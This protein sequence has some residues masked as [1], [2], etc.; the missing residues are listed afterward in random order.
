MSGSAGRGA[1]WTG[2][3]KAASAAAVVVLAVVAVLVVLNRGGRRERPVTA[4]APLPQKVD[5]KVRI[6]YVEFRG[7]KERVEF[8]A[9]RTYIGPDDM[10]HLTGNVQIIVHGRGE[11]RR[12]VV[13]G[14]EIVHDAGR[15]HY[16]FIGP[17]KL[18]YRGL[19]FLTA[20]V[21]YD[22]SRESFRTERR[23]DVLSPRLRGGALG[24]SYSLRSYTLSLDADVSVE[25]GDGEGAPPLSVRGQSLAF[26]QDARKGEIEGP[27]SL[28]RGRSGGSCDRLEFELFGG[29][30]LLSI[31]YFRGSA[32]LAFRGES[33]FPSAGDAG[34]RSLSGLGADQD[35]S[36]GEIKIRNFQD[37]ERLHSFETSG[38]ASIG[39]LS[40]DGS[41]TE[42][43]A[44]RIDFVFDREGGL[45]EFRSL[46]GARMEKKEA[47]GATRSAAGETMIMTGSSEWVAVRPGPGG[48]AGASLDA[49][50]IQADELD[51]GLER[52]DLEARGA[53][54][55][56]SGRGRDRTVGFFEQGRPSFA[57]AGEMR[58]LGRERRFLLRG[59]VRL[60]Q[61]KKTLTAEEFEFEEESGRAS[62]RSGVRAVFPHQPRSGRAE[63][64]VV[65]SSRSM[66][67]DPGEG[68]MTFAAEAR[69]LLERAEVLAESIVVR[70]GEGGL[71]LEGA[72]AEGDVVIIQGEREGRGRRAA[73]DEAS[74][75][76]VLTGR[77]VLTEKGRGRVEGDKLTFRLGD[78]TIIVENT[79]RERSVTVIKSQS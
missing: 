55:V 2:R 45:R 22:R 64:R 60:W 59:R 39:F 34:L 3:L 28:R 53:K 66:T 29:T 23:V 56:F 16:A 25:L 13:R 68:R 52:G 33:L 74:D 49:T 21:A 6:R 40:S 54:A 18:E 76:V 50:E 12:V 7:G 72:V 42:F 19:T 51:F 69:L 20:D 11:G 65:V 77:P 61:E 24:L 41:R 47:G 63:E 35:V 5:E 46:G 37:S 31:V 32:R 78:G 36:A 38:G 48:K 43:R 9:D 15:V 62:G 26:R 17:V 73:Y 44:E 10:Y 30:D 75:E 58:Y 8:T 71:G 79:G 27:V 14:E 4:V 57:T 1:G 67:S 70:L